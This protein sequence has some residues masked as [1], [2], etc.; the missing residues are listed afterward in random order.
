MEIANQE[1]NVLRRFQTLAPQV[2]MNEMVIFHARHKLLL[3]AWHEERSR[4]CGQIVANH[5]GASVFEVYQN[6]GHEL[7]LIVATPLKKKSVINALNHAYGW[8][9]ACMSPL[10]SKEL[11]QTIESYRNSV[12]SLTDACQRLLAKAQQYQCQLVLE[13]YLFDLADDDLQ[14]ELHDAHHDDKQSRT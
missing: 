5:Q 2:R 7:A 1:K 10:E 4:L 6:Y 14:E 9:S 3:L 8:M 12:V 13:Q 11:L